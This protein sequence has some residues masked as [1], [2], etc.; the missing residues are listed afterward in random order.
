MQYK[1]TAFAFIEYVPLRL[2]TQLKSRGLLLH[3]DNFMMYCDS[4]SVPSIMQFYSPPGD[5]EDY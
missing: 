2:I 4:M 3:F 5:L 1:N